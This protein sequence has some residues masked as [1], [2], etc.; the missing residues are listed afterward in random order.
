MDY[1]TYIHS[2]EWKIKAS[3]AII[4][5]GGKCQVCS[6]TK[7]LNVHHN[8]YDRLGA[9]LPTDLCVLC[10]HCHERFHEVKNG[11]A[12][13]MPQ[14]RKVEAKNKHYHA[15][16]QYKDLDL[17]GRR[18]KGFN[19]KLWRSI[20]SKRN[21]EESFEARVLRTNQQRQKEE[22]ERHFRARAGLMNPHDWKV[23]RSIKPEDCIEITTTPK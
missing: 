20:Q 23:F 15:G 10:K 22:D 18:P 3:E 21:R 8:T 11:K 16:T 6:S 9:E 4:R 17:S 14:S 2:S 1:Q 12:T 13:R 5:S 7:H 19:R